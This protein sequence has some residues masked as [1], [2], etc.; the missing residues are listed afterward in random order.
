MRPDLIARYADQRLPRY[1]SYPTAPHFSSAVGPDTYAGWLAET[2]AGTPASLYVHVPFCRRMCWYCGCN[3]AVTLRDEPV[4]A[5]GEM[6]KAEIA[7]VSRHLGKKLPVVHLHFGGGTPTI[8]PPSLFRDVMALLRETFDF[9]PNAEVAIEI[10][11]RT[12]THKMV[13]ALAAGG[14]NRA[15]LGVQ[16]LDP[17]VQKAIN[18]VQSYKQTADAVG[19]LRAA[20]ITG[21]NLDLIYGLPHQTV[22][23][24]IETVKDCLELEPDRIAVF[25]YAHVPSF[26][27][28]QRKI[29]T[30]ALPGGAERNAE[31][32]A[33]GATLIAAGYRKI[34]IDHYAHPDDSLAIAQAEGH[35]HRNFQ[36]YTTDPA[37]LLIGLGA[38]A[39]GRLPQGYAQND[40]IVR[41]YAQAIAANRLATVKGYALSADDRLRADLIE[42]LM[43]DF[44]V[45]VEAV[46]RRHGRT[47]GDLR[48]ALARVDEM[49][50]DGILEFRH[51]VI[52]MSAEAEGLTRAVAAVFDA[53]LP[54][55]TRVHSPA[56]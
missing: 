27:K 20:G 47:A 2:P 34:G 18:R 15:S 22:A 51:G 12:L 39:I 29:D 23:S 42:R 49:A 46:C 30:A 53:Y 9:R 36:G 52:E 4:A 35:L 56:L 38:S 17:V 6:L 3:T 14:I 7:M 26:K 16:S 25:G 40:P 54:A 50:A 5:Y 48:E 45:D 32:E 24:S 10:D 21:I 41:G 37:E 19:W 13:A 33:I 55:S 43:C 1:T 44:R 11:P 28:H 8:M 31:S